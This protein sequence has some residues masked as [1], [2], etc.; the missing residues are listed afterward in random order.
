MGWLLLVTGILI[1]LGAVVAIKVSQN[2]EQQSLA[3]LAYIGYLLGFFV[4]SL[5][6]KYLDVSLAYAVWSGL[7]SL[8]ILLVGVFFFKEAVSLPKMVFFMFVLVG[9]IGMSLTT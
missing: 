9:V 3:I 5:S 2:L 4:I 7:G 8:L 1:N 6:F